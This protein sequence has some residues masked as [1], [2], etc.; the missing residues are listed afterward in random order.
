MNK[1]G[2]YLTRIT[3]NENN[4]QKPSG[5][6]GKCS[7]SVDSPLYESSVGFGW[8]EWLFNTRN[9][10]GEYQYGFLE[11]FNKQSFNIEVNYEEVYLYTRKCVKNTNK[12][13]TYLVVKINNLKKLSDVEANEKKDHFE[14]SIEIMQSEIPDTK[15]SNLRPEKYVFNVKFKIEDAFFISEEKEI[16]V[17]NYR[18]NMIELNNENK[19]HVS[20]LN[21][22]ENAS[23]N[24]KIA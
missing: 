9:R 24:I 17:S 13:T 12:G 10:I 6:N 5:C 1:T 3:P 8:E 14:D 11:C 15:N 16:K 23:F 22:I 18:F 20:I 21:E 19:N 4:W 2:K 7:G